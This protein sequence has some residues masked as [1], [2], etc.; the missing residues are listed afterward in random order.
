MSFD[1]IAQVGNLLFSKFGK[2][3]ET[4]NRFDER[5]IPTSHDAERAVLKIS[6]FLPLPEIPPD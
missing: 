5:K 2:I 6:V 3:F 1:E 4:F